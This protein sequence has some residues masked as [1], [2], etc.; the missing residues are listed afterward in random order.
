MPERPHG[1]NWPPLE[2][3]ELILREKSRARES[4]A[5]RRGCVPTVVDAYHP[6]GRLGA[7]FGIGEPRWLLAL[8]NPA[9]IAVR[10]P[11]YL[12]YHTADTACR[13][14]D[15]RRAYALDSLF[16]VLPYLVCRRCGHRLEWPNFA[17]GDRVRT[18]NWQSHLV[19]GV[20]SL[21]LSAT[22]WLRR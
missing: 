21:I 12:R 18:R 22:R 6:G 16:R 8:E 19:H 15:H 10:L 17:I 1:Y 9:D 11:N 14:P 4:S 13:H 2:H 3:G 5:G 7:W 20:L